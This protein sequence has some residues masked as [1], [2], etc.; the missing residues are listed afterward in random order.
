LDE[1]DYKEVTLRK[2]IHDS[3]D[4][5]KKLKDAHKESLHK[6]K[7]HSEKI[8]KFVDGVNQKLAQH[9]LQK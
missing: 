5:T 7:R 4:E 2:M 1:S 8:N 9:V 6:L 3:K